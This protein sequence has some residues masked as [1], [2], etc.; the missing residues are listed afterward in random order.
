MTI[1]PI[2]AASAAL[3]LTPADLRKRGI[4]AEE[5]TAEYT[6]DLTREAFQQAG[7]PLGEPV[8]LELY[9][10]RCGVL[11][12]VHTSPPRGAVWRF[13]DSEAL[14]FAAANVDLSQ[15]GGALYWWQERYWLALPDPGERERAL[16]SE[17]G[18]RVRGDG[19]IR[20]RLEEYGTRLLSG[21]ALERLTRRR[22]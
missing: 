6:L 2:S 19:Y 20:E 12:F 21:G 18:Q 17:F 14:L 13:E 7:L 3:Y 16:L 8:E 9:P 4:R 11:I 5:L 22:L 10:D 15:S 1:Q